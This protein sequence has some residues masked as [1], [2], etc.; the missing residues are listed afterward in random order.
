VK[1]TAAH[2]VDLDGLRTYIDGKMQRYKLLFSVNGGA[3]AIVTLAVKNTPAGIDLDSVSVGGLTMEAIA[4]GAIS[5]TVLMTLDIWFFGQMMKEQVLHRFGF[6][7]EGKA[8]LLMIAALIIAAWTFASQMRK[9]LMVLP[10]IAGVVW[11][12]VH[13]ISSKRSRENSKRT[14]EVC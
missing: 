11:L 3:F 8:I 12:I 14:A 7:P 9:A 13:S 6:T 2:E 1:N 5:F 4:L 10:V